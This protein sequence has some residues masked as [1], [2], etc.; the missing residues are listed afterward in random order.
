MNFPKSLKNRDFL[1]CVKN[2]PIE[3]IRMF[4]VFSK[5]EGPL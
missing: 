2:L 4:D 5:S 1:K 3:K